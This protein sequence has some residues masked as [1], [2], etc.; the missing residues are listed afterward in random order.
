MRPGNTSRQNIAGQQRSPVKP[1]AYAAC[2]LYPVWQATV[3]P[4]GLPLLFG[5]QANFTYILELI[6]ELVPN[7]GKPHTA[8]LGKGLFEIRS[9]GREGISR[10]FFC[11]IHEKEVVI[12]HS[13]IKKSQ[14]APKKELDLATKRMKEI[15]NE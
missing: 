6:A 7:L 10:S 8:P 3:S 12:L 2:N 11:T 9:K 14:K 13:I 1:V 5:I 15:K 4:L